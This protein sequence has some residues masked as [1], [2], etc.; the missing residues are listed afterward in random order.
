LGFPAGKLKTITLDLSGVIQ[1]RRC[2]K[3]ALAVE[4][5]DLLGQAGMGGKTAGLDAENPTISI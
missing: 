4:Y 2:K 1:A 3:V 5:G